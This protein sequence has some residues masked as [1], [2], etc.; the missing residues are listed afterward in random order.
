MILLQ[1]P[2]TGNLAQWLIILES[3]ICLL[4]LEI[5]L[6]FMRKVVKN[7]NNIKSLEEKAYFWLFLGFSTMW[8]FFIISDYF[9]VDLSLRIIYLEFGYLSLAI[10]ASI[11]IFIIEK[12][13]IFRRKFLFSI[14]F[15]IY[16]IF[17]VILSLVQINIAQIFSVLFWVIF[18]IFFVY[19]SKELNSIFKKNPILGNYNKHLIK[20]FI[21]IALSMIGFGLTI[22]F[23]IS[24]IGLGSRLI[25]DILLLFA[26]F[27]LY[28]YFSS[29]PS[30][31]EYNWQQKV[32][33][34]YVI[35]KSGLLIFEKSFKP[36]E[37]FYDSATSGA[38][39]SLKMMLESV[40]TKETTSFIEKKGKVIT[41]HPGKYLYGTLISEENLIS[42]QI[43]LKNFIDEIEQTYGNILKNWDG[44]LKVFR[45][46]GQIAKEIFF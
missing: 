35:H 22:D 15:F 8:F 31:S 45:P 16:L 11:F 18:I 38:I 46:I 10:C 42:L 5:A 1:F 21:G 25:G 30:F 9:V 27:F 40:S 3:L 39:T 4:S 36:G 19:Y 29:I 24:F 37:T 7:K 20:L 28:F 13:K 6:I 44:D 33:S 26:L 41:I 14:I 23:T 17:F 12:Y 43:L 34:L 2:L 32:E